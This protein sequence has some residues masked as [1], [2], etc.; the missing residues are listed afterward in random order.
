MS[1]GVIEFIGRMFTLAGGFLMPWVGWLQISFLTKTYGITLG[2]QNYSIVEFSIAAILLILFI[3]GMLFGILTWFLIAARL[4]DVS[5]WEMKRVI[6]NVYRK[7]PRERMMNNYHM[8]CLR[9][10]YGKDN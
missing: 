8:W 2:E 3:F 7:D 4:F 9:L 5:L 10:V 1:E 6:S